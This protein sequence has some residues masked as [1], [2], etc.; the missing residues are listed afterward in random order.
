MH[1][2]VAAFVYYLAGSVIAGSILGAG[3]TTNLSPFPNGRQLKSL[4][5]IGTYIPLNL[6]GVDGGLIAKAGE[7]RPT[8]I[9]VHGR[10]ANRME[11]AAL[12]RAMFN[13]G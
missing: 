10:S 1:I 7:Q 5:S 8:I 13:E 9:Y 12:A 6:D 2:L 4:R 11:L 3:F